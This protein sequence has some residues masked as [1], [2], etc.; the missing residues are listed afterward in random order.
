[1][2]CI[3]YS[4][5]Y[6][7]ELFWRLVELRAQPKDEQ[8]RMGVLGHGCLDLRNIV[9]QYD[10]VSGRPI[11]AKFLDF[12][13]LTVASPVLDITYFLHSSVVPELAS[14]HHSLLIQIYHRSHLEAVKSFG[15]HGYEIELEDLLIE[16]QKK[17]EYGSM[18]A[19]L[20]KPALFVLQCIN[21]E[22][23]KPNR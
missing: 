12:S 9:F 8:V 4:R 6:L 18:M 13:T 20:L 5:R 7:Q 3:R 19:C 17:Q 23:E 1:M 10:D 16:Y 11:A 15:M 22:K 2:K 21:Q 14:H